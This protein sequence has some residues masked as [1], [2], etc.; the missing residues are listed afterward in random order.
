MAVVATARPAARGAGVGLGLAVAAGAVA[1]GLATAPYGRDY[2][3]FWAF[4]LAFGFVLQRSRFCFASGFRDLFLFG[5]SATLKGI[6]AG[7]A[8]A[9]VGFAL[10]E[11]KMVAMPGFGLLPPEAHLFPIGPHL[12]VGGV[13]FGVG[14]SLAG[15]C[16]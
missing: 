10:L 5:G 9:S 13:L 14:M 2:P 12:L 1:V 6:L 4:G 8:A 7:M 16:V 15:G 11:S 3:L